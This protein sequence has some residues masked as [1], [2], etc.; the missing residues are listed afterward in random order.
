[1]HNALTKILWWLCLLVAPL[2]LAVIELFHPANFTNTPG[3]YQY[4]S[5]PQPYNP[6]HQA[7]G[8]WGPE[9]WFTLHMIQTP[10]VALVAI[11][12]WLLASL[13]D[14][15]K[16]SAVILAWLSRVSAFVFLIYYTA[17]DSIGGSGLGRT[18]HITQ[19]LESQGDLTTSQS[20]GVALVLNKTWV[21]PWVGGVGSFIS[22]TGSWAA[23]FAALFAALAL[24][25]AK[26]I[27]WFPALLLVGFGWEL[28]M[29]HAM[30]H[31]PIAFALLIIAVIWIWRTGAHAASA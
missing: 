3:M 16:K 25:A 13:A 27:S 31:G 21:D 4:L 30:P 12:L 8:Y 24:L 26:K 28:Q 7:L 23:F 2:V 10:M 18:I 19:T 17:L 22:L 11:G 1:M 9:W 20:S 29:S 15:G 6:T 5:T 14:R